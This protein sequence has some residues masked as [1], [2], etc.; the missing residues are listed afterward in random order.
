MLEKLQIVADD[1]GHGR[2]FG[3]LDVGGTQRRQQPLFGLA[4]SKKQNA[5]R[6]QV[7]A[8]GP[9]LHQVIKLAQQ[10]VADGLVEPGIVR[11]GLAKE[12]IESVVT[13]S[14]AHCVSEISGDFTCER[15]LSDRRQC[16]RYKWCLRARRSLSTW[17]P[18]R[19]RR[20]ESRGRLRSCRHGAN[21]ELFS[22]R[23]F[24]LRQA[25]RQLV[26]ADAQKLL[27][28]F[29]HHRSGHRGALGDHVLVAD[30]QR[31]GHCKF[32]GLALRARQPERPGP[33]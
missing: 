21:G 5:R 1:C 20:A 24:H 13:K 32:H 18:C 22:I 7:G 8:G 6:R 23:G 28:L 15:P 26:A 19:C 3:L 16:S 9:V 14:V 12:N 25:E 30:L 10:M 2:L 31:L 33:G 17:R 4:R 29:A 11:A 27:A